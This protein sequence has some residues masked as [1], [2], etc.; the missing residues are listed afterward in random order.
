[1]ADVVVQ[2]YRPGA[3]AR[4][5]L[6]PDDLTERHPHL[7]VVTLS[8]WGAAGPWAARRGF[9]SLVQC[10]T[11]IAVAEGDER[12]P[13]S[14]P[15]QILD[16]ATGYLAAAAALLALADVERGEPPRSVQLSLAQTAQWL[17]GAG[18][19]EREPSCDPPPERFLVSLPGSVQPVQVISPP[20][21][22]GDLRP[23]WTWTTE[24]GADSPNFA[25]QQATVDTSLRS[26][27]PR[28]SA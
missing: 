7:S 20:G 3:L 6:A 15:A 25:T 9:D 21:A 22:I 1:M 23:R 19:S 12:G 17:T 8:A 28:W 11:G 4:Y 2:G 27:R 24:F 14:L 16:H 5:G 10:P 26:R 18:T 13:G